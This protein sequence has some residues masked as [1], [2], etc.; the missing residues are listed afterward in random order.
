MRVVV[1]FEPEADP[2]AALE[3]LYERTSLEVTIPIDLVALVDGRPVRMSLPELVDGWLAGRD[4]SV[5]RRDLTAVAE[6]FG[7]PRRTQLGPG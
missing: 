1:A 4:R 7:V 3:R 2:A 5:V 6:R